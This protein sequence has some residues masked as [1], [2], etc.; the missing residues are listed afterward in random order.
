MDRS[1]R[2]LTGKVRWALPWV[3]IALGTLIRLPQLGHGLNEMY[4]WREMQVAYV[5]LEYARHG[6]NLLH[7]PLP[8]LGPNGDLPI[9]FPLMQAA[10]ACLSRLA[11]APTP[12]GGSSG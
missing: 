8:V 11:S 1:E 6:I 5:A 2:D 10:A 7:T 3:V 4:A 12:R 9:E